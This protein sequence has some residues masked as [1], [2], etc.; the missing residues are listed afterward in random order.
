MDWLKNASYLKKL[1]TT[2]LNSLLV[3]FFFPFP[4]SLRPIH[5]IL[6]NPFHL[7]GKIPFPLS[8]QRNTAGWACFGL[9]AETEGLPGRVTSL[10]PNSRERPLP[11][12]LV[13]NKCFLR[14]KKFAHSVE[15]QW[16]CVL[17]FNQ[18]HP[19]PQSHLENS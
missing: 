10:H 17:W 7:T 12:S 14:W 19:H 13:E 8:Q 11:I 6:S 5:G 15:P 9:F 1:G 18:L 4:F 2:I 3:V 16:H